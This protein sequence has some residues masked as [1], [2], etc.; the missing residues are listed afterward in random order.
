MGG[1]GAKTENFPEGL[2]ET[3][4]PKISFKFSRPCGE[5]QLILVDE[6]SEARSS[7]NFSLALE[8][9]MNPERYIVELPHPTQQKKTLAAK[10]FW[11]F[12][13]T[14]RCCT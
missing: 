9:T 4:A 10:K 8:K 13:V 3:E 6:Q 5:Y 11:S 2:N 1:G 7:S 14:E 12:T